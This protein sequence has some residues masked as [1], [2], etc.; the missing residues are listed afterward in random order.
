MALAVI[1]H[2]EY[3]REVDVFNGEPTVEEVARYLLDKYDF[4][5]GG[6]GYV[7]S[8]FDL[9]TPDGFVLLS[10]WGNLRDVLC[11]KAGLDY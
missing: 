2:F 10:D 4:V 3:G 8:G 1:S 7:G 11:E 6:S 5:S 9:Y